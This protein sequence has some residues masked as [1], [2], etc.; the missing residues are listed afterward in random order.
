MEHIPIEKLNDYINGLIGAD[1]RFKIKEHL[2]SCS[3]CKNKYD[4]EENINKG[5]QEVPMKAVS[6]DFVENVMNNL[7]Q[8]KKREIRISRIS[9]FGIIGFIIVFFWV[10]M[11]MFLSSSEMFFLGLSDLIDNSSSL[12]SLYFQIKGILETSKSI[13]S[14]LFNNFDFK[15][16]IPFAAIFLIYVLINKIFDKE[17][18]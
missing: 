7:A 6:F 18:V 5:L 3:K 4:F 10:L 16:I 11:Y 17:K 12:K 1:E 15:V 9:M 13:L 14:N 8:E 2:D